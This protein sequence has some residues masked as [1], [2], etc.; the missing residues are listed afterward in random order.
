MGKNVL[1]IVSVI[2]LSVSL[3]QQGAY[4]QNKNIK[5]AMMLWRG[6]L[7]SEKGFRETLE[8]LGYTP[9]YTVFDAK[10][11]KKKLAILLRTE[12]APRPDAFDYYY[13]FGTT[14]SK[15]TK[16]FLKN[17]V[18][19]VFTI[20]LDPVKAKLVKNPEAPGENI[21][22][23]MIKVP[24]EEQL[25]N[26]LQIRKI[27]KIAIIYNT[28]EKNS[29]IQVS[30]MEKSARK[31]GFQIIQL[32]SPTVEVL[33][34]NLKKLTAKEIDADAVY[35]PSDSF[36]ASQAPRIASYTNAARILTIGGSSAFVKE[37]IFISTSFDYYASG[38]S[39]AEIIDRH[40]KGE[41]LENIAVQKNPPA[42]F[43]NKTTAEL[44]GVEIPE[45]I[46]KK[47]TFY[48]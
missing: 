32:P 13:T 30:E 48:E 20:V 2:C 37:G 1:L 27:K 19:Q 46:L 5:I 21:S 44:L 18:P 12:L 24:L 42:V 31:Y 8:K 26:V 25:D 7:E 34:K 6:E 39:A 9:E 36:L 14:V 16:D 3:F 28:G 17:R 10:Q 4:A 33:E 40:Q 15:M 11:N 38:K 41:K 45:S 22:G 35:L 23:A 47:A 29:I 43:I